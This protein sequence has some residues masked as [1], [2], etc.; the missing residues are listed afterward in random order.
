MHSKIKL[1][2]LAAVLV[3]MSA[4]GGVGDDSSGDS[5]S[6]SGSSSSNSI[7]GTWITTDGSQ[8]WTFLGSATS[9]SGYYETL[10]LDGHTCDTIF[11]TYSNVDLGSGSFSYTGVGEQWT[12]AYPVA[13]T[14]TPPPNQFNS[15]VSVNGNTAVIEGTTFVQGGSACGNIPGASSQHS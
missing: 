1:T 6:G 11:I 2:L 13:Y 3:T 9:G 14:P 7:T 12:G 8:S 15:S 5:G 4:C 10:S